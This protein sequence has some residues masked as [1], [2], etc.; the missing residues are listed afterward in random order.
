M[1][2]R[3]GDPQPTARALNCRLNDENG[4]VQIDV[5][6][7]QPQ[8]LGQPFRSGVKRSVGAAPI[9]V[10]DLDEVTFRGS[11]AT[12]TIIEAIRTLMDHQALK[13]ITGQTT[14]QVVDVMDGS[15][16][17]IGQ[18]VSQ[19][20]S[21]W[22]SP[23]KWRDSKNKGIFIKAGMVWV[24]VVVCPISGYLTKSRHLA[25]VETASSPPR[26]RDAHREPVLHL[27]RRVPSQRQPV[28]GCG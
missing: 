19:H 1:V 15:S 20:G 4:F 10:L 12:A 11:I 14:A 3:L 27:S 25:L 23:R 17:R 18:L 13:L 7:A 24:T 16:R 6:P 5:R 2:L 22:F 8:Q 21:P 26:R 9:V 28:R